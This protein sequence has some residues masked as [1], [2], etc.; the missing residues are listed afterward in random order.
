LFRKVASHPNGLC[1]L[2]SEKQ[3]DFF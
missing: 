2:A 1:A 3:R